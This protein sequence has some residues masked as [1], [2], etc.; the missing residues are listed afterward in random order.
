MLVRILAILEVEPC[1]KN[2]LLSRT[3]L[4]TP[5]LSRY[6]DLLLRLDL[7][8]KADSN[9]FTITD[10]GRSFLQKYEKL[11]DLIGK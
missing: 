1:N 6:I 9:C 7:V 8:S 10:K 4:A 2:S 11:V 5:S 3:N